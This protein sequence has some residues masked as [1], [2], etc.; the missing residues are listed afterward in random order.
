[1]GDLLN[2]TGIIGVVGVIATG[3]AVALLGTVRALRETVDDLR[4]RVSDLEHER[5][6][7][8]GKLT[9]AADRLETSQADLETIKRVVTGEVHWVTL[10]QL[11][12]DLI[13]RF[14]RLTERLE[15]FL[16]G[17]GN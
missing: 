10:E 4:G 8:K 7:L 6:D 9:D 14:G 3:F 12:R 13:D 17:G 5:D 2:P 1:M 11:L 16:R 15:A